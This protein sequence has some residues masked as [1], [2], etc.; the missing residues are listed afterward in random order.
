M[1]LV[2][3][4]TNNMENERK[5]QESLQRLNC[6]VLISSSMVE[7][8]Y[9]DAEEISVFLGQ[10]QWVIVSE[11]ILEQDF[12]L[13][14]TQ[15]MRQ[16]H[17]II[18][19]KVSSLSDVL[20]QKTLPKGCH[21]LPRDSS[22]EELREKFSQSLIEKRTSVIKEGREERQIKIQEQVTLFSQD[23]AKSEYRLFAYLLQHE[24]QVIAREQLCHLLWQEGVSQSHS[25]QL[26]NIRRM[27]TKKL[28]KHGMNGVKLLTVWREGYRL[29]LN[30][31]AL[32]QEELRTAMKNE[33]EGAFK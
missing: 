20:E 24:D 9:Y 28:E 7:Q 1:K 29:R 26:S 11:T 22:M 31:P 18:Y 21:W 12:Q 15:L 13:M 6:E 32:V 23:L 33:S 30:C 3:I 19:R 8:L 5:L 4:V 17:L 25:A 2:L 10:V 27:L 16:E 14:A